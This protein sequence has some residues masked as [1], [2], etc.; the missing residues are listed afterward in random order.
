MSDNPIANGDNMKPRIEP[1]AVIDL[2]EQYID[3]ELHDAERYVNRSPFGDS[4]CWSLHR[5]AADIYAQGYADGE[6]AQGVRGRREAL[7]QREAREK[8]SE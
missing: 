3:K 5:L 4:G 6:Q 1:Q 8:A 2:V 7:R